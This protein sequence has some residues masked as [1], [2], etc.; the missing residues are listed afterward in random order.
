[1][2]KTRHPP[3]LYTAV[4]IASL[5]GF[6]FGYSNGIIG[7]AILF[8]RSELAIGSGSQEL[9]VSAALFGAI[10]G[11]FA[12]GIFA[13]RIGRRKVLI[14]ASTLFAIGA[15]GSGLASSLGLLIGAR[16]IIGLGIGTVFV[17]SPLYIAEISPSHDRGRLTAINSLAT[18]IGFFVAFCVEYFSASS[19]A[20]RFM[21]ELG[22]IPAVLLG[23][24]MLFMPES[25]PWLSLRGLKTEALTSLRHLRGSDQVDDEIQA[26]APQTGVAKSDA[27]ASLFSRAVR[28]PLQ[29]GIGL[30][31]F[32]S[33]SGVSIVALYSPTILDLAHF[34]S[35]TKSF[36]TTIGLGAV[37]T[38]AR[39]FVMQI[40]DQ[41]GRRWLMLNGTA[42][43][44][45]GLS[46][47]GL[48]F[49]LPDGNALL[50]WLAILGLVLIAVAYNLP[51]SVVPVI[52]AEIFPQKIRG[53]A[54][55]V[56]NVLL[57]SLDFLVAATF[58]SLIQFLGRPGTF[59]TY[60]II[61]VMCWLFVMR[62]V[63][64]TKGKTLQEIEVSWTT[65]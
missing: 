16:V 43:V 7:W 10:I 27:D 54:M 8:I 1:M 29:I 28:S 63:P 40:I 62:Y 35:S 64:E 50:P 36:L 48:T 65:K 24:G 15:I 26:M 11:S 18:A 47:L 38:L 53:R 30:A 51:A 49:M 59:F 55:S 21:L 61:N 3:L 17:V 31:V 2:P 46:V 37:F 12:A 25:P 33:L 56:A 41:V 44:I 23:F 58:L 9:I 42:F 39:V 13:D 20:W 52:L 45:L 19:G 22:A 60:V 4:V 6:S 57:W 32:R 34:Q 14:A 5:G